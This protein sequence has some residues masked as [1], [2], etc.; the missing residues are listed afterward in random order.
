MVFT[1]LATMRLE[2]L[3]VAPDVGVWAAMIAINVCR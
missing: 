1:G 2:G 3:S